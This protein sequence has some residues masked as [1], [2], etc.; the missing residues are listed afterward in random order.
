MNIK[1]FDRFYAAYYAEIFRFCFTRIKNRQEADDLTDEAFVKAYYNFN[2]CKKTSFRTF[3]FKIAKNLCDEVRAIAE[4]LKP[5]LLYISK[6]AKEESFEE[7]AGNFSNVHLATHCIFEETQPMYSRI[8]FAQDDDPA[9]DGF[10]H[11]YEV[12]NLNL[13]AELVTLGACETGLGKLSRGEGLIGL[14]RAFMYAGTPSVVVSL[15]SVDES[16]AKLMTY[17]YQNFKDG[18]T[19][20]E[21]LRQ[22]KLKMLSLRRIFPPEQE[23]S[24]AQPYLWAPF[25]LIGGR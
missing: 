2:P 13:N 7:K 12:F 21:A 23:F 15:W 11:T 17:F 8:V 6:E 4:I 24:F 18:M 25:V 14:T 10:S 9:E 20:V 3:I 22:A 1:N 5:L 16:T 19:K